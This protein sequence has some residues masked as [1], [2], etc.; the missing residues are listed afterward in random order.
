[1][2]FWLPIACTRSVK[3]RAPLC[4]VNLDR[5]VW[6]LMIGAAFSPSCCSRRP[7]LVLIGPTA[8]YRKGAK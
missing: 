6:I 1:M 3:V 4:F 7:P 5:P 2:P 8:S